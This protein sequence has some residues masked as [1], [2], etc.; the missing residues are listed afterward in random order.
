MTLLRR[1]VDGAYPIS[2]AQFFSMHPDVQT[3][4][5]PSDTTIINSRGFDIVHP[6]EAP[7]YTALDTLIEA[8]P[9]FNADKNRWEQV[10]R[11]EDISSTLDPELIAGVIAKARFDY[12][13]YLE[14]ARLKAEAAGVVREGHVIPTDEKAFNEITSALLYLQSEPHT[15]LDLPTPTGGW[16]TADLK[17]VTGIFKIMNAH[18]QRCR[19]KARAAYVT[20]QDLRHPT[21]MQVLVD[22][23]EW[24]T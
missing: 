12:I 4:A 19:A 11:V 24:P 17:F 20:L 9:V 6:T 22:S 14:A 3:N 5:H 10:W 13:E 16:V 1:R 7:S 2:V 15:L 18:R 8:Q 23:I 21:D